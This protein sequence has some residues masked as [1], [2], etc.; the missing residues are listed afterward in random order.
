MGEQ[1]ALCLFRCIARNFFEH[2]KLTFLDGL[3]FVE[4]F[5]SFLNLFRNLFLAQSKLS[6]T[7]QF[8]LDERSLFPVNDAEALAEKIDWWIEH[9][10]E[11]KAMSKRYAAS[12]KRYDISESTRQIITMYEEALQ[13]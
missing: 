5:V 4:F 8:A 11:R 12:A 2:L 3:D 9:P 1:I 6:A 13:R 7:H 10:A